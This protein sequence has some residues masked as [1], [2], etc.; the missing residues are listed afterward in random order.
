M[1]DFQYFFLFDTYT[2]SKTTT[3]KL[4]MIKIFTCIAFGAIKTC[5]IFVIFSYLQRAKGMLLQCVVALVR[6]FCDLNILLF[7]DGMVP[8]AR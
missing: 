4:A 5:G 6:I 7:Q 2:I 3:R 8:G 1:E